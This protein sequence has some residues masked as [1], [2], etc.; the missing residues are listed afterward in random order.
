M[1]KNC[2]ICYN[3]Q[4]CAKTREKYVRVKVDLFSMTFGKISILKKCKNAK[5]LQVSEVNNSNVLA[6]NRRAE[7]GI[8]RNILI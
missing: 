1:S 8:S 5:H 2:K 4:N 7:V 3:R 6:G